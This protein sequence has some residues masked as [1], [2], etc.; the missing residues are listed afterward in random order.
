M[1]RDRGKLM[2]NGPVQFTRMKTPQRRHG[3]ISFETRRVR[4]GGLKDSDVVAVADLDS[5]G[6]P[7]ND[8]TLDCEVPCRVVSLDKNFSALGHGA[9]VNGIGVAPAVEIGIDKDVRRRP[10]RQFFLSKNRTALGH[11]EMFNAV[12]GVRYLDG[13]VGS[14]KAAR[15]NDL[16]IRV[17]D[18]GGRYERGHS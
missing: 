8:E 4:P 5:G 11:L 14:H 18:N 9:K 10:I 13:N 15:G 16:P 3:T 17:S 12:P 1:L 7:V 2:A 6:C